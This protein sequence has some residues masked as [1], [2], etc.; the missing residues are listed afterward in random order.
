MNVVS[1]DRPWIRQPTKVFNQKF[2]IAFALLTISTVTIAAF[3]WIQAHAYGTNWD[4]A[5]YINRAYRDVAVF[6]KGGLG[7]LL[8]VLVQ[9]DRSRPPAYRLLAL[10]ITLLF[11]VSPTLVRLISLVS[12]WVSL[13]FIYLAGRRIAG[14]TAGTFAVIFLSVCPIII[15][16][17]MRFYVDFP[18]YIAVAAILYFLFSDWNSEEQSSRNW[19]GLG[20]ALGLGGLAKPPILFVAGP[21]MLLTLLFSW[22]KVI[23]SPS[24]ASLCKATGL[25]IALMLPWWVFNVKP[26]IVKAFLSG[27]YARHSL[28]AERSLETTFKW[29]NAFAQSMLGPALTVLTLAILATLVIKLVQNQI[30]INVTQRTAIWIC[31]AGALPMLFLALMKSNHNVRL[32]AV[33]LLPLAV[34]IGIIAALTGWTTSRWLAAIATAVIC[35]QLVVIV[36]PSAADS[37]YQSGDAASKKLLWGNPTTVMRRTEQLNWSKL[38]EICDARQIK[39]PLIAYLGN[40]SGLNPPSIAYPWIKADQTVEVMWLW[41]SVV[42]GEIDWD[43]VM[44]AVEASDVVLVAPNPAVSTTN[45]A[46]RKDLDNQHNA[47][48]AQRMQQVAQFQ[49]PIEVTLGRFNPVKFLVFSR[50]PDQPPTS[51]SSIPTLDIF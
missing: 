19:I 23:A 40:A 43:K 25:A 20:L 9:E 39:S 33:T 36:S 18:L 7:E 5:R 10:P 47:E 17:S 34:A 49:S 13:G 38:R 28:G 51:E 31:L 1:T 16:P 32:I 44:K 30:Q 8:R 24:I 29:L 35:F 3:F 11:G 15:G 45:N 37:H 42:D 48:F 12:L 50:K 41:N 4:E 6:K 26:A 27:A 2:W 14:S 46:D 21:I 22:R